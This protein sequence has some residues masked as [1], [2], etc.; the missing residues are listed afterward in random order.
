MMSKKA[1]YLIVMLLSV[2]MNQGFYIL[3]SD[4]V[5]DLPFWLDIAGTAFAA[6][7]LEPAAGLLV[8]FTNNFYLAVTRGDSSSLLYFA[9]SAA[10]AV[11]AGVC[12]RKEGRLSLKRVLPTMG[13]IVA[14][15][16]VISGLL[17]LWRTGGVPDAKWELFYFNQGLSWGWPKALCCFFGV[18]VIKVYDILATTAIVGAFW[19][20]LPKKLKNPGDVPAGE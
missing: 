16:T 19:F 7:V 1:R 17:T 2:A 13:L 20:L 11:I 8:G 15:T 18:L 6:I 12:M 9:A 5:L 3:A 10:V 4:N 14:V